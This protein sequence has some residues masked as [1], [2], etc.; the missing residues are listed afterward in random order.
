MP[1]AVQGNTD[2]ETRNN[3]VTH[4]ESDPNRCP[5]QALHSLFE[6][7]YCCTKDAVLMLDAMV[8]SFSHAWHRIRQVIVQDQHDTNT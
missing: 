2:G 4:G 6:L 1:R 8:A 5:N 3:F 7:H